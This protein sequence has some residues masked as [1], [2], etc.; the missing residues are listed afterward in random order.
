MCFVSTEDI[1]V[2]GEHVNLYLCDTA[3]QVSPYV[4]T[5]DCQDCLFVK[6]TCRQKTDHVSV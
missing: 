4:E 1:T 2:C 5:P 3:G 6:L